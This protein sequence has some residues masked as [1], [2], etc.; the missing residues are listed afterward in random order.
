MT[1][2]SILIHD[3]NTPI[4]KLKEFIEKRT[5]VPTHH[6]KLTVG[7][8]VLEDWDKDKNMMFIGDYPAIQ[9]GSVVYIVQHNRHFRVIVV[10]QSR[11]RDSKEI[12]NLHGKSDYSYQTTQLY[13]NTSE[14]E[15][16]C[17]LDKIR[18]CSNFREA[19]L[20][21]QYGQRKQSRR[22]FRGCYPHQ[23]TTG[24]QYYTEPW[25][26]DEIPVY[27]AEPNDRIELICDY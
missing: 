2:K 6:Q 10:K 16:K 1:F 8:T 22:T 17:V 11:Y 23:M 12:I 3:Q 25:P 26:F 5:N 4:V 7:T 9:N 24:D 20:Y 14:A 19:I 18:S 21:D 13:V 15:R 27:Y